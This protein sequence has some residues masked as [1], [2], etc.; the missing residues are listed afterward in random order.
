MAAML[1]LG[2]AT[3]LLILGLRPVRAQRFVLIVVDALR[4]DHVGCYGYPQRVTPNIDA[5][6]EIARVYEN[7]RSA[8]SWTLPSNAALLTGEFPYQVASSNRL[9]LRSDCLTMAERFHGAGYRTAEF[10]SS[11]MVTSVFNFRQGFGAYVYA[12]SDQKKITAEAMRWIRR[13]ADEPFF[14]L[15]YYVGP[16]HPYETEEPYRSRFVRPGP[17]LPERV[18][19]GW[20]PALETTAPD[21]V[22]ESAEYLHSCYLAR[23]A[24]TDA[25]VGQLLRAIPE[26]TVVLITADHGEAWLEHGRFTHSNSL[27]EEELRIPFILRIPGGQPQRVSTAVANYDVLPTFLDLAG[28]KRPSGLVGASLLRAIPPRT[29]LS[30]LGVWQRPPELVR[31]LATC[32][33][34]DGC[35][36]I[37]HRD[38]DRYE[39]YDLRRDPAEHHS[40]PPSQPEF[41]D[42]R[43]AAQS[44]A[45]AARNRESSPGPLSDEAER[46]LRSLG[47]VR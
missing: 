44:L 46:T 21:V 32:A 17:G 25:L 9:E 11:G 6:A 10:T 19:E 16:H 3:T 42:L 18:L 23:I 36:V 4:S 2:F 26:D 29:I 22:E 15:V 39:T 40:L 28:L 27:Y 13:Q 12:E 7:A 30:Q 8:S 41:R 31:P 1:L 37:Y 35:K 33:Y 38:Q 24:A 47:Y 43:I 34:R 45:K 20:P 5:F 14:A